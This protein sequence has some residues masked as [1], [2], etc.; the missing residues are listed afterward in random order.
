MLNASRLVKELIEDNW[1]SANTGSRTPEFS[2]YKDKKRPDS[3]NR[4]DVVYTYN[5]VSDESPTA[6]GNVAR[7]VVNRVS[8]D[9]RT[10]ESDDQANLM[11]KE[12]K[13][14]IRNNVNYLVPEGVSHSTVGQQVVIEITGTT[15]FSNTTD[16]NY[17]HNYKRVIE[18]NLTSH[19][20]LV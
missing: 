4:T 5:R 7:K 13:R 12:I 18:V 9:L 1:N 11:E 10:S 19:M 3:Y 8:V 2:E 14:I 15:P 16:S 6:V 20:E 17:V